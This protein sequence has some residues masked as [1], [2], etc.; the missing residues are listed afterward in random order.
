MKIR[1]LIPISAI[2]LCGACVQ[3]SEKQVRSETKVEKREP[4]EKLLVLPWKA[5]YN[6]ELQK[7]Q[8]KYVQGSKAGNLTAQD[9]IDALNLK[10]PAVQLQNKG[11]VADTLHVE[12]PNPAK[13]TEG[14]GSAGAESFLA[15]ATFSLT[16]IKRY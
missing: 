10:Y 4:E 5:E 11:R 7:M 2:F 13:L 16:G 12:I 8:M 3:D 15:E 6:A 14:S 1:N 9:M